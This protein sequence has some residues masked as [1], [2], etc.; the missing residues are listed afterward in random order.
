MRALIVLAVL[1]LAGCGTVHN[2]QRSCTH[3]CNIGG[4]ATYVPAA[5]VYVAPPPPV[6]WTPHY[7]WEY[8]RHRRDTVII[9]Q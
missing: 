9:V 3:D 4:G 8:G 5:P 7:Y 6:Y 2:D 1:A